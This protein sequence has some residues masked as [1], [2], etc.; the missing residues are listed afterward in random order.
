MRWE[1]VIAIA[2]MIVAFAYYRFRIFQDQRYGQLTGFT[3]RLKSLCKVSFIRIPKNASTSIYDHLGTCNLIRDEKLAALSKKERYNSIFAP[4][5]CLISEAVEHIGTEILKHPLFCVSR[6]PYDRMVS[7]YTYTRL[8]LGV[9]I[10]TFTD[11]VDFCISVHGNERYSLLWMPQKDYLDLDI[12]ITVLRFEN[13]EEDF[14]NFVADN[15]LL[16]SSELP[17]LNHSNDYPYQSY[18]DGELRGKV[19]KMWKVD[20][21][22]LNYDR[23]LETGREKRSVVRH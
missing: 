11:F 20:F 8:K 7:L 18:Y 6:N 13:L 5:H 19:Y 17:W 9:P 2:A 16:I 22:S 14:A 15:D 23:N 12:G 3:K 1:L 21:V 10:K 4:S